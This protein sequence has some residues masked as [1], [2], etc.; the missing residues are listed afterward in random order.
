MYRSFGDDGGGTSQWHRE[1]GWEL[2]SVIREHSLAPKHDLL[3]SRGTP[4]TVVS[5]RA[6][7]AGVGP[8]L[9]G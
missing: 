7:G 8:E 4:Q 3:T 2:N 1:E 9:G 5:R 6:V